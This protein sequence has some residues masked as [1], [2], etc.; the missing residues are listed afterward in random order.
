MKQEI[1][2]QF[3]NGDTLKRIDETVIIEFKGRREVL[4]S[5]VYNGG[6]RDDLQA[7]L[8]NHPT[9][10]E[11]AKSLEEY[12][13]KMQGLCV[14]LGYDPQK[15]SAL[16]TGV[17]MQNVVI[18]TETTDDLQITTVVTA[19]AEG[20]P[21]RVGDPAVFAGK[22][23]RNPAAG[24]INIMLYFNAA[25]LPGTMARALVTATEAKTAALQ[26]LLLGSKYSSGLA[27]G[28]GT[29]QILAV[30][31]PD[32]KYLLNDCGKHTKP[33]EM[34]GRL[35]K[36]AVKE[37]L[38]KQN[39]FDGRKMHDVFRRMERFG[40]TKEA[41]L[42][43]YKEIYKVPV[44]EELLLA[45]MSALNNQPRLLALTSLYAHLLDQLS[46]QLLDAEEAADAGKLLLES[47]TECSEFNV[48]ARQISA[49]AWK[50]AYLFLLNRMV[51]GE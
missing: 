14:N 8:N 39:G 7:V 2:F 1:L 42:I 20:N 15:V 4:S 41:M 24:T 29:D 43:D 47:M 22:T 48:E 46:W 44:S 36:A 34:L 26:E 51:Q 3:E 19:G 17:S 38:K 35:V 30:S 5:S 11:E 13:L 40:I 45:K 10:D 18:K 9:G 28:T 50:N 6:W 27:T 37:A 31:Y 23:L 32:G 33:G 21:G 12:L 25:V 16:G 49:A